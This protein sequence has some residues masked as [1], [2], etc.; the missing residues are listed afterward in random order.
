MIRALAERLSRN[1][2]L[3]RRLPPELGSLR[4]F[5]T[6]GS[7][8]AYW[9]RDLRRVDPTLLSVVREHIRPGDV[10]W[11]VGAN[12]GLF[13]IA[14]AGLAGPSGR[15]LLVEADTWLVG[16]L[17]RSA[18]AARA[19]G[20]HVDVLP[21]AASDA[22]GIAEFEIARRGRAANYLADA[23]GSTSTGGVREAQLVPTVSL[24]WLLERFP[25]PRFLKIDVEGAED[26]VLRGATRLLAEARPVLLCEVTG[27]VRDAVTA[28]LRQ[29]R[30]RLYDAE[31]EASARRPLES[32]AWNT[33]A[34]P[35]EVEPAHASPSGVEPAH[36]SR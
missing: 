12:V 25:A 8:L 21:A 13:G 32:A 31:A 1:V 14:A 29:A 20:L 34:Y 3:R 4:L 33:L 24:D 16:L 9:R 10:V 5:V 35:I 19:T 7:M 28:I 18:A 36:A 27:R 22:V 2:V 17:R 15:V 6:P 11:D 30:Y 26:R 23:M